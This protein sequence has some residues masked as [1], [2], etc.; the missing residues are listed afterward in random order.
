MSDTP[1]T[2]SPTVISPDGGVVAWFARNHVAANLLMLSILF[3]GAFGLSTTRVETMPNVQFDQVIVT[4]PY[5]G[6][7]PEEVEEAVVIKVEEA[8]KN[9]EGVKEVTS[10]AAEGFGRVMI[11]I[12]DGYDLAAAMDEIKIAVDGIATFP[13]ETERPVIGKWKFQKSAIA[14]QVYGSVDE[15]TL[16]SVADDLRDEIVAL[17]EVTTAE[18]WGGRPYEIAIEVNEQTLKQYGLT[19]ERVAQVIR[20][21][22]IDLPG[23]SIRTEG[24]DIRLRTKGQAYNG[25]EFASIVLLTRPD[26]TRLRLA[27]VAVI[28]D[29]FVETESH[30]FFDAQPSIGVMVFSTDRDNEIKVSEAVHKLVDERSASLPPGIKISAWADSAYYLKG[31]LGMLLSNMAQGAVLVFI[32]LAIFLHWKIAGWV[33]CGLP[34]AFLGAFML[35]PLPGIGISINTLSLF[36]FILVLGIVVDDAIVV[37]EAVHTE[38]EKNGY[39][40]DNIIIAAKRVAAP[41]TF[42]VLTTIMAF[43]PMLFVT[44]PVQAMAGSIG[45]VVILCLS[46]SLIE[47][48]LILPSH[49]AMMIP[50]RQSTVSV[51]RKDDWLKR[52]IA[53]GYRPFLAKAITHRYLTMA[54]FLAALI[55]AVGVVAGG[56]VRYVFFPEMGSDYI[57]A[58]VEMTEGVSESRVIEIVDH[59]SASLDVVNQQLNKAEGGENVIRHVFAYV[60]DGRSGRFQVELTRSENRSTTPVDIENAWRD[61]VGVVPDTKF[62]R[63]ESSRHT[64]GGPPIAFKVSGPDYQSIDAAASELAAYLRSTRGVFEVESSADQGPAEIKLKILPEAE[65]LGITLQ[66][67]AR[68][69]RTAFYGAE[70]QRIQRGDDEVKVMVRYPRS[71][72]ISI[73]SLESMWIRMPDG[74][75]LPFSVVAT[76]TMDRGFTAIQRIDNQRAVS[77]TARSDEQV[78]APAM[79]TRKVL[80]EFAVDLK[81]RYPD[82]AISLTGSG[83]EEQIAF[84]LIMIGFAISMFGIYALLAIPLKSYVQPLIIMGVIPFGIVGAIVGHWAMDMA[85]S[86][87]SLFGIIALSGVVVNDSLLMIDFV[88]TAVD[89]GKPASEAAIDSGAQRFRAILLTSLT[90]F[91]GL[92]PML[93]QTS[94]QAQIVQPMA[95]SLAFGILFSTVITLILVPTLYVIGDDIARALGR[96]YRSPVPVPQEK[97]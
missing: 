29:G 61:A 66:D 6:A 85:I 84:R 27:D 62:I 36:G 92:V 67:L 20:T 72:R 54:I 95:T 89:E 65:A 3:L 37:A 80:E 51:I 5:L 97:F 70:A 63:F 22:S 38:T 47:S 88:N 26:G 23:G 8:I 52:F 44:G 53:N 12:A 90:T 79:V 59:M 41:V 45:W 49:L 13:G 64:G 87:I 55:L 50:A 57:S 19:L 76:Y 73:G 93:A 34:I 78:A 68:Q 30:A 77:I 1:T 86:A 17:P 31:S 91:F 74:R 32:T 4:V 33:L 35:L 43:L 83:N 28:R 48:K 96:G 15:T 18:V 25:D 81:T 2:I 16:K 46:F 58:T 11:E 24:G 75:E 71:E 10:T 39:S 94:V 56:L 60:Q 14:V 69:V 9:V 40:L 82:V 21:W 7:A 42:G